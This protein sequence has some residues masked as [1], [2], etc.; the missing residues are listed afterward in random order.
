MEDSAEIYGEDGFEQDF[1]GSEV[2]TSEAKPAK[3]APGASRELGSSGSISKQEMG[4]WSPKSL[5]KEETSAKGGD[6]FD[7]DDDFEETLEVEKPSRHEGAE[8]YTDD[9]EQDS[10]TN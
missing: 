9:F 6:T 8:A 2:E 7:S 5:S 3:K 10:E 4:R 1:E